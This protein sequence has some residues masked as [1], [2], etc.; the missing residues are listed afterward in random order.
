M[1]VPISYDAVKNTYSLS[2]TDSNFSRR[3][4]FINPSPAPDV[5]IVATGSPDPTE[6]GYSKDDCYMSG[7]YSDLQTVTH[8]GAGSFVYTYTAFATFAQ[9]G[10]SFTSGASANDTLAVF[11]FLTPAASVPRSGSATY[12]LDL[13][14]TKPGTGSGKVDFGGGTY[15]FSG[16]LNSNNVG[17]FGGTFSSNGTLA[18]SANGFS[19]YIDVT[20]KLDYAGSSGA[21]VN[22]TTTYRGVLGGAFFGPQAQ[23]LGGVFNAPAVTASSTD[24]SN[25]APAP[26]AISAFTG[27]IL[28]HK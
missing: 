8:T 13:M 4:D 22:Q 5:K 25:P 9:G 19:G 7:C 26:N 18:S 3:V 10:D 17:T 12:T 15:S 21:M 28:G 2:Y 16:T 27:A 23:E 14:G 24:P 6:I 20:T 1:E 11:G